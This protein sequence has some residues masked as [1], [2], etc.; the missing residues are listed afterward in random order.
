MSLLDD[1]FAVITTCPERHATHDPMWRILQ[2]A[3]RWEVE[4]RFA[5]SSARANRSRRAWR[6]AAA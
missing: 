1:V 2:A 4:E 5:G 3:A 6:R